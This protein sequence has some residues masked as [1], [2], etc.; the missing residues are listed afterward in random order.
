MKDYTNF[1][2][3]NPEDEEELECLCSESE[4][5]ICNDCGAEVDW[6]ERTF[7]KED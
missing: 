6:V 1:E 3:V 5:G 2:I 7:G 4:N